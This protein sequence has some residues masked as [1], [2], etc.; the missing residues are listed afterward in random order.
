M[1]ISF[2]IA[3]LAYQSI[4]VFGYLTFGS[5]VESNIIGMYP[6]SSSLIS[7]GQLAI[8]ITLMFGF[9]L[10][11]HPCRQMVG[12]SLASL[13]GPSKTIVR[14]PD[15]AEPG[16]EPAIPLRPTITPLMNMILTS[17]ILACAFWVA[18]LVDNLEMGNIL[19][20]LR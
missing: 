8:V 4:S 18:Y 6:S 19:E 20:A 15:G 14:Y 11:L 9:P 12:D 13:L 5:N 16:D 10:V 1:A 2:G 3:F 7:V 17:F